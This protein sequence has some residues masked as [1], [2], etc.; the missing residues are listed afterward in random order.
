MINL[1]SEFIEFHDK[2]RLSYDD[3]SELREKRD[4]LLKKLKDNIVTDAASFSS[5][6]QGSYAMHTGIKPDNGDYDIDV[7]LRFDLMRSDYSDPVTVKQ[8]VF[9][10][11]NGHTKKVEI[12][13]SCVTVTYQE[14]GEDAYHVD[15][16]CY[17]D[18][19]DSLY[20]AKGKKSSSKEN[21]NWEKSDP[22]GLINKMKDLFPDEDDRSQFRRIIRYMKKWKNKHFVSSGN[23][24]PTGIA[25]TALAFDKFLPSYEINVATGKRA[26]NDFAALKAFV[27][28][29]RDAF[30][31]KYD[32]QDAKFYHAISQNLFVVPYNNLFAK[33]TLRQQDNFYNK[34]C[35]M[36]SR[37]EEA[38]KKNKKSEACS[39]LAEVFGSDFPVKTE[40]SY[41]GHSE[42]A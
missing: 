12:R 29:C 39:I 14:D 3:N 16:A 34:L 9:D 17:A 20:I 30:T 32:I 21:R 27:A 40:R 19:S 41:V 35:N 6:N 13:R 38:E 37:L 5:F 26:Y 15:F 18:E 25:L 4:I 22:L 1:Q 23:D 42:S 11:L 33:M 31:L 24:A 2:I 36:L 7:G 28:K 8:W 10:A